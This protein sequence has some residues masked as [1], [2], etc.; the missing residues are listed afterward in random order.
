M[1]NPTKLHR[2]RSGSRPELWPRGR[3]QSPPPG[4]RG[5]AEGWP[6]YHHNGLTP[7]TL[8]DSPPQQPALSSCSQNNLRLT[9]PPDAYPEF[10]DTTV[11]LSPAATSQVPG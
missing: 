5:Q 10:H 1:T 6:V 4:L 3:C 2:S 11:C 7:A 8:A 9:R